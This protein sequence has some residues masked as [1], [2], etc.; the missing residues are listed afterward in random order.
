MQNKSTII[1]NYCL[2][3]RRKGRS[4]NRISLRVSGTYNKKAWCNYLLGNETNKAI[5]PRC[6]Y[7]NNKD[8]YKKPGVNSK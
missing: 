3:T 7:S 5:L 1:Y 2:Y 6:K 8:R 4:T